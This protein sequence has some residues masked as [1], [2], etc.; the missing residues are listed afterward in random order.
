MIRA[1]DDFQFLMNI[2]YSALMGMFHDAKPITQRLHVFGVLGFIIFFSIVI[3]DFFYDAIFPNHQGHTFTLRGLTQFMMVIVQ[4][5]L[6][7]R[8]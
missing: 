1:R 3:A 7:W 5:F 4:S 8:E 6:I 2:Y